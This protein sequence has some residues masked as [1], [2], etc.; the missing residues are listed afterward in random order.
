MPV[1]AFWSLTV[2]NRDGFLEANDL[3]VYNINSVTGHRDADG[4]ITVRLGGDPSLPNCVP[5]TDG[6]NYT[7]R[8]YRPRPEI[9][10]GSWTFPEPT[11]V[12]ERPA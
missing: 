8:L 5:L 2:Y 6:W 10:D 12:G 1:D 7:V 4:S 9:L 11:P 3:G